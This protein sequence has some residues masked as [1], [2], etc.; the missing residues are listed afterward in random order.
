MSRDHD[1]AEALE[2]ALAVAPDACEDRQLI[3]LLGARGF[4]YGARSATNL[5]LLA[6]IFP[7]NTLCAI[8]LAALSTPMPDMALN[9]LERIGAIVPHDDLRAVCA[10][11]RRLSQLLAICG[12]SPFLTNIIC[13]D[14]SH[15]RALFQED[16][17]ELRRGEAEMLAALRARVGEGTGYQALFPAL[18]RFKTAEVL[19]IAARDLNGLSPLEEVT[20]ELSALAAATLQVACEVSRR[21]LIAE[22]G[23]PLARTSAGEEKS[24][25]TI[26]GMGKF[27]GRELNF[28]SDIDIIFL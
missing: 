21:E 27:G 9:G 17:I 22:Y 11:K 8:T 1:F 16:G 6:R 18:R 10:K 5:R 3:T 23:V 25:L 28:S 7:F 4:T 2:A 15:F 19:R 20:A 13:R 14:P 26:I 12:S 24:E